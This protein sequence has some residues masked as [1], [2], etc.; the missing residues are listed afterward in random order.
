M[1]PQAVSAVTIEYANGVFISCEETVST[2]LAKTIEVYMCC[3]LVTH[4]TP[5]LQVT[6]D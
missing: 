2:L 3:L 5:L 6:T 1:M 4:A